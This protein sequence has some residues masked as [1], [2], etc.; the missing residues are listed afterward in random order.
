M[1]P[2][3]LCKEPSSDS[4]CQAANYMLPHKVPRTFY[5][6]GLD[7]MCCFGLSS[8]ARL[9]YAKLRKSSVGARTRD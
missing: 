9:I 5:Q 7:N 1:D 3:G 6:K 4:E 2:L 8:L